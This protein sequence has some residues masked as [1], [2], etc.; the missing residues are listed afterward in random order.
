MACQRIGKYF[1]YN[2]ATSLQININIS[3]VIWIR[4]AFGIFIYEMAFGRTPFYPYRMDQTLLFGKVLRAQ[5]DIPKSFSADLKNLLG[6]LLIVDISQRYGCT[7]K[8]MD[9]IKS[10][11]WFSTIKWNDIERQAVRAPLKPIV[12]D[13]GDTTNFSFYTEERTRNSSVCNYEKEFAEY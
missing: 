10:H 12:K 5:F 11:K 13:A 1:T 4:W 3:S 9:D 7:D 2:F 6:R 8:N